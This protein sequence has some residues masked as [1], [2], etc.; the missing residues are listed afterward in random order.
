MSTY[1]FEYAKVDEKEYPL[2]P[3]SLRHGSQE[4]TT[5]ALIDSGATISVFRSEIA[6]ALEMDWRKG[7]E[8]LL[9]SANAK[10]VAYVNKIKVGIEDTQLTL[11]IAFTEEL[12]T[13]FNILGRQGFFE[14]FIVEINERNKIV[15]L[16]RAFE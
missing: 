13:S 12:A 9:Q 10:F 16:T 11:K 2:I 14:S 6:E 8:M 15:K 3:I 1:R 5:L 4:L 7:E